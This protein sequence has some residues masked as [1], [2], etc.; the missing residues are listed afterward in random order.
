MS[1]KK[2]VR[3][4]NQEIMPVISVLGS[5]AAMEVIKAVTNKFTPISQWMVY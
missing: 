3:S 2:L 5:L 1:I 4:S